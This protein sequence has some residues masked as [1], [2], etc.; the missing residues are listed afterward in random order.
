MC[1]DVN[2]DNQLSMILKDGAVIAAD[3]NASTV[4]VCSIDGVVIE[5]PAKF[6]LYK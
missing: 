6:F 2:E 4:W 5:Y 1:A 3:V